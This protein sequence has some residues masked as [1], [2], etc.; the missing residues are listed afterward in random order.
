VRRLVGG[1]YELRSQSEVLPDLDVA[2]LSRFVRPGE[3][4]TALAKAYQ[5]SLGK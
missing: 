4:Q 2:Q 1:R 3:S 5:A